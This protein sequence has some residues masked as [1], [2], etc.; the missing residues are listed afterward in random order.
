MRHSRD[1]VLRDALENLLV[2]NAIQLRQT[3][4]CSWEHR[5]PYAAAAAAP[6]IRFGREACIRQNTS[7]SVSICQHTLRERD[8]GKSA[9]VSIR[10]HTSAYAN[11]PCAS[12]MSFWG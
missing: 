7:A 2:H 8:E 3:A 11:I 4:E 10:Q 1:G 6:R 12:E 9:Y 5:H